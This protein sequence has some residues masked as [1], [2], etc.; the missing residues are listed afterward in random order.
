MRYSIIETD[1]CAVESSHETLDQAL[2]HYDERCTLRE[3]RSGAELVRRTT[4]GLHHR[5]RDNATDEWVAPGESG[6]VTEG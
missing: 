6:S 1:I 2:A 4:Y 3:W 5:I